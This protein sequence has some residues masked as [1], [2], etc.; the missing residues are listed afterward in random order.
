MKFLSFRSPALLDGRR[1]ATHWRY[2][3]LL[4][5]RYKQ[6]KVERDP[7]FIKDGKFYTTAGVTAGILEER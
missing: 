3:D 7:I 2:C 6:L 1:V 4:I 5:S